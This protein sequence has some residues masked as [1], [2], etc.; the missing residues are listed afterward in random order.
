M[1]VSSL[2]PRPL[3]PPATTAAP[4]PSKDANLPKELLD[5]RIGKGTVRSEIDRSI[6]VRLEGEGAPSTRT[7]VP[8]SAAA[9]ELLASK[10]GPT[11]DRAMRSF[12][13]VADP[14]QG[15][16]NLKTITFLPD[17]HASKG[18][19][20]LNQLSQ[21][22]KDGLDQALN[23]TMP[24]VVKYK[25]A[26]PDATPQQAISAL[27]KQAA[28]TVA[29]SITKGEAEQVSFAAAWNADGN[30][31]VMPDVSREMLSTLGL[32]R[33]Q[34]GDSLQQRPVEQRADRARRAWHTALHEAHHSISPMDAR[35]PEWTSVM[36]EAVPEVLTPQSIQP[37]IQ[38]AGADVS[39]AAR[40]A[41]DTKHEA[42]DWPAWNLDHLPPPSKSETAT[43]KGRYTDGPT[44]VRSLLGMA[45]I[46]RR[47]TEGK[48]TTLDLLQGETASRVPRR[49]ADAIVA[50]VGGDAG[51]APQL[52]D[53]IRQTAIG[54][55]TIADIKAFVTSLQGA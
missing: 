28:S 30:I 22:G 26:H 32:Y 43:A 38:R 46:D 35:G 4:I 49:V 51:A 55:G 3:T 40:P 15:H 21:F 39:L 50:H 54:K 16:E 19:S 23:P 14:H 27:R 9:V 13:A 2:A 20:I 25:Q 12:L 33:I 52:A 8:D 10:D 41:R 18:V 47:T 7:L 36:E 6:R 34:P 29:K 37:T 45:G 5:A 17:E 44:L 1:Q 11:F 53:K 31:V 42:V 48:A 24:D